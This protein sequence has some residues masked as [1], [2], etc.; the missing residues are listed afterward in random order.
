MSKDLNRFFSK[1]DKIFNRH[2]KRWS[3]WLIIREMQIKTEIWAATCQ[4]QFS[5]FA[6]PCLTLQPHR[7]QD[8]ACSHSCPSTRWRHP[9]IS[10]SVVPFSSCLQSF[11]ASGSFPV[12]Q[13]FPSGGQSVGVSV[14]GSV[15][16]MN[17][18]N[19]FPLGGTGLIFAVQGTLKSLLQY[20]ISI[21]PH[22]TYFMFQLSHPYMTTG[23]TI[24]LL[25][26]V[27]AF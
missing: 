8:R 23:K 4:N 3:T 14:S 13:F 5:S 17:I 7:L 11:P 25:T 21:L 2:M 15:L 20:H 18:D 19:W 26:K 27:S 10:S 24:A 1:E 12:N 22:S 16:S 9:T 6:Q